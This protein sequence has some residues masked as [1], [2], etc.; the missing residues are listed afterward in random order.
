MDLFQQFLESNG[1]LEWGKY[2]QNQFYIKIYT[3]RDRSEIPSYDYQNYSFSV[4][5]QL[6]LQRENLVALY[7]EHLH[8]AHEISTIAGINDFFSQINLATIFCDSVAVPRTSYF[9]DIKP[10]DKALFFSML[11]T[12]KAIYGSDSSHLANRI[13]LEIRQI[14]WIDFQALEPESGTYTPLSIPMLT[15]HYFDQQTKC[16]ETDSLT[17]GKYLIYEGLAHELDHI[18]DEQLHPGRSSKGHIGSEYHILK[19][20]GKLLAPH[21]EHRQLLELASLALSCRNPGA[22]LV[23]FLYSIHQAP[24]PKLFLEEKKQQTQNMLREQLPKIKESI[25]QIREQYRPKDAL[26]QAITH[27]SSHMIAGLEQRIEDPTFEIEVTFDPKKNLAKYIPLCD[28]MYVLDEPDKYMT[29][30]L[31]TYLSPNLSYDLKIYLC[32]I[33][34]FQS[35]TTLARSK[36][37][38]ENHTCPLYSCC[39]CQM[40]KTDPQICQT[41]PRESFEWSIRNS[42]QCPYYYG[43][44]YTNGTDQSP[45]Y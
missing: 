25:E 43:V 12:R 13:V 9:Q 14:D 37:K 33:D 16:Y 27:L 36:D 21:I 18:L 8:Y 10:Q 7:H 26:Y 34:Y 20:L 42:V 38:T 19:L 40:R 17:L 45:R 39:N 2:I 30:F 35:M 11:N 28:M 23:H 15:Y 4:E 24:E 6:A 1:T 44:A 5:D 32:Y 22:C 31:G 29:E 3:H 41:Q